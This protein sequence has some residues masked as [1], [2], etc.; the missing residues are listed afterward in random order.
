MRGI[1][2]I[3]GRPLRTVRDVDDERLQNVREVA[4]KTENP[5]VV[6]GIFFRV[7]NFS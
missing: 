6:R 3:L 2:I 5:S 4:F 7:E 1:V